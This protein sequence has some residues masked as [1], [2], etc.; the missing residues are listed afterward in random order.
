MP[1]WSNTFKMMPNHNE[2]AT[3]LIDTLEDSVAKCKDLL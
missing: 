1:D 3:R 2:L